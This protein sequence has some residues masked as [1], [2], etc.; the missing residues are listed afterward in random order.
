M[1][2]ES[3]LRDP[4]TW[5]DLLVQ[6]RVTLWNTVPPLL[7]MLVEYLETHPLTFS[8]SCLRLA[9]LS[10]DWIPVTLPDRLRKLIPTVDII[11]LGGA[12]EA[13]IWSIL[14]PI[15]SVDPSWN[16]IPYGKPM[17]NQRFFVLNERLELC[18]TWIPVISHWWGLV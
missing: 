11:S 7:E 6:E 15:Q 14:Y 10:G 5:L 12:T 18:P 16:S 8:Q 17:R 3:T 9:L 2:A 4:A 1:P 13:S